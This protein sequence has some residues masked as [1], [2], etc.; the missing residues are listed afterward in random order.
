M[1]GLGVV[2]REV[3]L[4][5][6]R[7]GVTGFECVI[8]RLIFKEGRLGAVGLRHAA[9]LQQ[10]RRFQQV[11]RFL[12]VKRRAQSHKQQAILRT[13]PGDAQSLVEALPQTLGKGQRPAQIQNVALDR[14]SLRQTRDGLIHHRLI[15][16]LGDVGG[17]GP[18]VDEG[19]DVALGKHAAAG[20][21]GVGLFRCLGGFVHLLRA[22]FQQRGHLVDEGPGAAGA[23]AVHPDLHTVG[24]KEDLGILAAQF[25]D[26]V[27]PRCQTVGR[28]P[29]SEHLLH[30]GSL[31]ALRHAHAGRAGDG[32]HRLPAAALRHPPQKLC[33]FLYN[34][35]VMPLV[36]MVYQ[37]VPVIQHHAFDGGG[38]YVKSDPQGEFLL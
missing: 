8:F 34:M 27:R 19:L 2:R 3:R 37:V 24:Q 23:G 20:G 4:R 29:G 6:R 35:A 10:L 1:D 13:G 11:P 15:D 16:A 22:H 5:H 38:A 31:Y 33:G 12:G 32:K 17:L 18:L 28:H 7:L 21:D 14:P 30:K 26:N 9:L 36:C 25:D